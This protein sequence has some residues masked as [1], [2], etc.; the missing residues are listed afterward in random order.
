MRRSVAP[1][2]DGHTQNAIYRR[3]SPDEAS[4][5]FKCVLEYVSNITPSQWLEVLNKN[6]LPLC[7]DSSGKVSCWVF[8][9]ISSA[10]DAHA[11]PK[12]L[13][14][15]FDHNY[16]CIPRSHASTCLTRVNL[17]RSMVVVPFVWEIFW[18][19]FHNMSYVME[20]VLSHLETYAPP[21]GAQCLLF[22]FHLTVQVRWF[23]RFR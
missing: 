7:G 23:V 10:C 6:S 18:Y 8:I 22:N 2:T 20:D 5:C 16:R 1:S 19:L 14:T 21:C 13:G 4:M 15:C 3:V 9:W 12:W 17:C 11:R